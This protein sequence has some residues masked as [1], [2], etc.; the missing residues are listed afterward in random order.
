[1]G[2]A[3]SKQGKHTGKNTFLNA[4]CQ[5]WITDSHSR[6]MKTRGLS[7]LENYLGNLLKVPFQSKYMVRVR[8][9]KSENV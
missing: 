3:Y 2:A 8:K 7:A 6:N 9:N 5:L 4:S 1:M